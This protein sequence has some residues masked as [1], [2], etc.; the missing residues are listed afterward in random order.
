MQSSG[1]IRLEQ[2]TAARSV[3]LYTAYKRW[4][5]DN[6]EIPLSQKTF[7]QYLTQNAGTYGILYSKHV[8]D[9]QRGFK[10]I[11]V[12]IDPD[13]PGAMEDTFFR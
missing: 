13:K 3:Y 12:L 11:L 8:I 7:S 5:K 10:N 9:N 2:D 1:Y 6:L 4:C